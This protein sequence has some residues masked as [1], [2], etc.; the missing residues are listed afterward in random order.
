MTQVAGITHHPIAECNRIPGAQS[1]K[2]LLIQS[3]ENRKGRWSSALQDL[4]YSC[5]AVSVGRKLRRAVKFAMKEQ[6]RILPVWYRYACNDYAMTRCDLP[7]HCI[8]ELSASMLGFECHGKFPLS[9]AA[10]YKH[11]LPRVP[12]SGLPYECCDCDAVEEL[13]VVLLED[14]KREEEEEWVTDD[15]EEVLESGDEDNYREMLD[16]EE[17]APTRS[18][19]SLSS[20]RSSPLKPPSLSSRPSPAA[21]ELPTT[22]KDQKVKKTVTFFDM[23]PQGRGRKVQLRSLATQKKKKKHQSLLPLQGQR[24]KQPNGNLS[25]AS[26]YEEEGQLKKAAASS[27]PIIKEAS[28]LMPAESVA[29]G[30]LAGTEPC[31]IPPCLGASPLREPAIKEVAT[32][33]PAPSNAPE[34]RP[35]VT[36]AQEVM[37]M[38]VKSP[39]A[40]LK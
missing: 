39:G 23:Q 34:R 36:A 8:P 35:A 10:S 28:K 33:V 25:Q 40:K 14:F 29:G 27:S 31:T 21:S 5:G 19:P 38:P 17:T 2:G 37:G 26:P 32:K 13:D 6:K 20:H 4:G 30:R 22:S 1:A 15:E 12:R 11:G 7:A 9:F 16:A 24:N 18:N 3:D